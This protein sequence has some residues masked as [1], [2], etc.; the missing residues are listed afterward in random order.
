MME[1]S[2]HF[3]IQDAMRMAQSPAGQQLLS[4]L[5]QKNTDELQQAMAQA[6]T[7]NYTAAQKLLTELMQDPKAMALLSQLGGK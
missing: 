7:G 5:Q 1:K 4:M 6:S 3:S 2:D